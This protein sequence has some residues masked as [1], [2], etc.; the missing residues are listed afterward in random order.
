MLAESP[1]MFSGSGP[2]AQA[3]DGCSVELYA[4]LPY[5]DDLEPIRRFVEPGACVLELGCGTGRLTRKLIEWGLHPT[6]VDNSPEMLARLPA[7]AT[8]VLSAIESLMLSQRFDLVLLASCLINH[9]SDATRSA[10]VATAAR[11]VKPG[12]R[13]L[14]Q[15]QNPPW[16][17]GAAV[18][19]VG[20]AGPAEIHLEAVARKGQ[21]VEMRL[22]Y[23]IDDRHWT[24]A[25]SVEELD[26]P[27]IEDLLAQHGLGSISWLDTQRSW[28]A[29]T[30]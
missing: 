25:F 24:H 4:E 9:P 3:P 27:Q 2:G 7:R 5:L 30:R 1:I 16:L 11:H 14:V 17:R 21:T 12:G 15:R 18:G 19:R 28:A 26:E 29:A 13:L 8:P 10:F 20:Q 23:Q 6:S 22:R